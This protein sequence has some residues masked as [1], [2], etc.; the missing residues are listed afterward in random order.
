MSTGLVL[1][2]TEVSGNIESD[3]IWSASS[4]P[5]VVTETVQVLQG[6][7][8]IIEPGVVIKFNQDAGLNIDGEL[9]AIGSENNLIVFT[10]Q[11]SSWKGILFSNNA[12]KSVLDDNLNY[13]RGSIIKFSKIE[14]AGIPFQK[15]AIQSSVSVYLN[16]NEIKNSF[17][18]G[19]DISV[20]DSFQSNCAVTN[21]IING[22]SSSNNKGLMID[23]C[24]KGLVA[25]NNFDFNS[26]FGLIIK[27][28]NEIII[29]NNSINNIRYY[30]NEHSAGIFIANAN[31]SAILISDNTIKN[32]YT[33]IW[34]DSSDSVNTISNN[35]II[36]NTYGI[37][38]S[39]H[40]RTLLNN[41]NLDN[42]RYNFYYRKQGGSNMDVNAKYNYWGSIN[43]LDIETKIN[44]YYDDVSLGKVTYNP[45]GLAELKFNGADTFSEI[46]VCASWT[47]SDWT[48][49]SNG[50]KQ[51]R[52]VLSSLPSNCV[53]GSPIVS[54]SCSYVP[55]TC[56]SWTYSEWSSCQP[57]G[58]K[59]RTITSSSPSGCSGGSPMM[60][61]MSC[62]DAQTDTPCA[63]YA[64]SNWDSC[65]PNNIQYRRLVSTQPTICFVGNPSPVFTQSCT[66]TAPVCTSWSYSSWSGCYQNGTRTRSAES[67]FPN[68][69]IGGQ[70]FLTE[71]CAYTGNRKDADTVKIITNKEEKS[72]EVSLVVKEVLS[73]E[74]SLETQKDVKLINRLK[75]KILL[76]VESMGE[77]WYV[78]PSDGKKIYMANGNEAYNIMRNEGIGIT[79]TDLEKIK[80][81]KNS[82]IKHSGKIFLQVQDKGQAYYIDFKGVAVYLQNGSKAFEL[83]RSSGMGISNKDIRKVEVDI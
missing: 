70:P 51:T 64:Y 10:G 66:Y 19:V 2:D 48:T 32:N 31:S 28:N 58:T 82:A 47:Y 27:S 15:C 21:N 73:R 9:Y 46:D 1:A 17:W 6:A 38:S 24:K 74:Q 53:G 76:Q 29:K 23:G 83:M 14:F 79:N 62:T 75:G 54:Q 7:K 13:L 81:N 61:T 56:T 50:G 26:S 67:S 33:G 77:A 44:D 20:N 49:C 25:D 65:Q 8:L 12:V 72:A 68:N 69:C 80:N 39:N 4:S 34:I 71:L 59:T 30:N 40:G 16:S 52:T 35:N 41:N 11:G 45:N 42:I 22:F 63:S 43:K 3:V 5:Y 18:C 60:L 36:N 37:Q 57:S 55:L 78:S